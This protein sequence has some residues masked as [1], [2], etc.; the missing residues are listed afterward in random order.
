MLTEMRRQPAQRS[1]GLQATHRPRQVQDDAASQ[2][3][4]NERDVNLFAPSRRPSCSATTKSPWN[5]AKAVRTVYLDNQIIQIARTSRRLRDNAAVS[6]AT[7]LHR[8]MR[9]PSTDPDSAKRS[10][11]HDATEKDTK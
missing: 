10:I 3:G 7:N 5:L 2:Q 9:W 11:D 6:L 8:K 4:H 1:F